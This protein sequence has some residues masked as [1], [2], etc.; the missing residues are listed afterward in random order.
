MLRTVFLLMLLVPLAT[1]SRSES[2]SEEGSASEESAGGQSTQQGKLPEILVTAQKREENLERV[3]VS[4]QV[5]NGDSLAEQ[6]QNSLSD[7]TPTVPAVHVSRS[8]LFDGG[9]SKLFEGVPG[10][11]G[12][13]LRC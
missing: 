9:L 10:S 11:G 8:G 5:I 6:N 4:V 7:L 12:G 13:A 2:D 1:Y 3:P